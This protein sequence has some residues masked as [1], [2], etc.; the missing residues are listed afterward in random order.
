MIT[1][2]KKSSPHKGMPIETLND[3]FFNKNTVELLDERAKEII[4]V[5][6]CS[7]MV[8][9][10]TV[11]SR[12]DGLALNIDKISTGCKT[13]LNI[14]Y[15]PDRIFDIRECGDNALELI[16]SLPEGNIICDYPLISFDME[17]VY[18]ADKKG[19]REIDSY[20]ALKE[21]WQNEN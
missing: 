3:I 20:E 1:V 10:Y 13:V 17:K 8:N 2:Y 21:W 4:A 12:F 11:K 9:K 7:E 19:K 18:V 14:I 6:D 5:L 15:N 16:Y